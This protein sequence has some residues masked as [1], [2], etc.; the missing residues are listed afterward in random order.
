MAQKRGNGADPGRGVDENGV[1]IR[2]LTDPRILVELGAQLSVA[3]AARQLAIPPATLRR[4]LAEMK[5]AAAL[6]LF[7][8]TTWA[9]TATEIGEISFGHGRRMLAQAEGIARSIKARRSVP[10]GRV[11]IVAPV[12]LGQQTLCPIVAEFLHANPGSEV[13]LD[14]SNLRVDLVEGRFDLAIRVGP[15]GERELIVQTLGQV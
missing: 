9:V 2:D 14:V 10:A 4:R 6:R 13:T 12:I 8:R 1:I 3:A 15:P 7:D 5:R 11:P